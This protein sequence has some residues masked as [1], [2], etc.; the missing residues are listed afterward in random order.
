[1]TTPEMPGFQASTFRHQGR[2]HP[3]YRPAPGRR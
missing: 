3:V 1:M 2:S